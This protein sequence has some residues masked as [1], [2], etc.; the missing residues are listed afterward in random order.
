MKDVFDRSRY[1]SGY[2]VSE[3]VQKILAERL[4]NRDPAPPSQTEDRIIYANPDRTSI[5]DNVTQP[6]QLRM[7]EIPE[8]GDEKDFEEKTLAPSGRR[9]SSSPVE[10]QHIVV[11]RNV[12]DDDQYLDG[13][14]RYEDIGAAEGV[15]GCATSLEN[16]RDSSCRSP[17]NV[18]DAMN[19]DG[20]EMEG[21]EARG[22]GT[23]RSAAGR[24]VI[25]SEE[26]RRHES[27]GVTEVPT[28]TSTGRRD[29]YGRTIPADAVEIKVQMEHDNRADG[30]SRSYSE[31]SSAAGRSV[32][33]SSDVYRGIGEMKAGASGHAMRQE[34]YSGHAEISARSSSGDGWSR[35]SS[36]K[37][38]GKAVTD[39]DRIWIPVI[40]VSGSPASN[41]QVTKSS[42]PVLTKTENDEAFRSTSGGHGQ[43]ISSQRRSADVADSRQ[44]RSGSSG[45]RQSTK[46]AAEAGE[47]CAG[48]QAAAASTL[49]TGS[50]VGSYGFRSSIVVEPGQGRPAATARAGVVV[51]QSAGDGDW[52]VEKAL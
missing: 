49:R 35:V 50:G 31:R 52:V 15:G 40:H 29:A 21:V 34:S 24:T 23:T 47:M 43:V 13:G 51:Q 19:G 7:P 27:H 18:P 3:L 2:D 26:T 45:S 39:D 9:W 30:S 28:S 5:L 38:S 22:T 4:R 25:T 33:T 8:G 6:L 20:L 48:Q 37:S 1:G 32:H 12:F 41:S 36:T 42:D 14:L 10:S 16:W 46:A 17:S 11:V 44:E